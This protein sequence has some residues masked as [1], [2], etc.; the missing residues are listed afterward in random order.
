[1]PK[2][3]QASKIDFNQIAVACGIGSRKG[4]VIKFIQTGRPSGLRPHE[5]RA[6]RQQLNGTGVRPGELK[7]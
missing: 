2:N 3:A 1:M 4:E 5:E 6:V 7:L